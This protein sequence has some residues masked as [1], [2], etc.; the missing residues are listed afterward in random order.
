MSPEEKLLA[1]QETL[2]T[3][4]ALLLLSEEKAFSLAEIVKNHE[5]S[6]GTI[7]RAIEISGKLVHD[8]ACMVDDA[9][10]DIRQALHDQRR[11]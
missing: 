7:G 4:R 9:H 8:A 11:A 6:L 2:H 5:M 1:A 10:A 3:A